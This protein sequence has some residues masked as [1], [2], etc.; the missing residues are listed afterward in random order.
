MQ[1]ILVIDDEKSMCE[2]FELFLS[3][4]GFNPII[5]NGGEE[6][7]RKVNTENYDLVITDIQMPGV[8]G[9]EILKSVKAKDPNCPVI[10]ITAY[11]TPELAAES[12][13]LGAQ[14]YLPK[15][16]SNDLV[17]ATI[18]EALSKRKVVLENKS[19]REELKSTKILDSIVGGSESIKKLKLVINKVARSNTNVMIVGESGTG[20]ELTAQAIHEISDRS[21][22]S[23]IPFNCG[24]IPEDL[25]ESELFGYEKGAFTGA[26]KS[27]RGLFEAADGGTLFLDEVTE[28]PLHHQV[29]L[30]RVLQ[31]E[32][33]MP[34]G[35]T[36][37]RKVNVRIIAATNKSPADLVKNNLFREDLFYRLNV[38]EVKTPPLRERKDDIAILSN[39]LIQKIAQKNQKAVKA[40]EPEVI[41]TFE[42]YSWPGN[43]RELENVLERTIILETGDSINMESLPDY[44]I[45]PQQEKICLPTSLENTVD[46]DN[47]LNDLEY[48]IVKDTFF[49]YSGN[50]KL[51]AK[52]LNITLRSLRYRLQKY[53]IS[54]EV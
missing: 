50:Q 28:F 43:I 26:E 35:S 34:I 24:A 19:L 45:S 27:K 16:F 7:L 10:T 9:I 17:L 22:H 46:L 54:F 23:F 21:Q 33:I 12:M 1:T 44:I 15:P 53:N 38:I 32:E 3:S 30:L 8:N 11:A 5:A 31:E 2:F 47:A 48:K 37:P 40:I 13:I 25:F 39:Y 18:N 6:G 41:K 20:K 36:K 14:G 51:T 29:K 4:H 52:K 49:Q 42:K